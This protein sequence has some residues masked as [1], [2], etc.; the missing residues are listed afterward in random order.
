M[1]LKRPETTSTTGATSSHRPLLTVPRT[2]AAYDLQNI[3]EELELNG[4]PPSTAGEPQLPS[5]LITFAP[6]FPPL[7]PID[8]FCPPGSYHS[9]LESTLRG[10][11]AVPYPASIPPTARM[12]PTP[13]ID[14]PRVDTK[15]RRS[16][17]HDL[18]AAHP[19]PDND[20]EDLEAGMPAGWPYSHWRD[21]AWLAWEW[22]QSMQSLLMNLME[23]EHRLG[24]G[25]AYDMN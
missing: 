18:E 13:N 19:A 22:I 25:E 1:C 4:V 20:N 9:D 24:G 6:N 7:S 3:F 5:P 15:Q 10:V 14:N 11:P 23:Q 2:S 8:L 16:R 12:L 17:H 21:Y